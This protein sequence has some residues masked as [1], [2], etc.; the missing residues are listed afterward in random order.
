MFICMFK[1]KPYV[2]TIA[3]GGDTFVQHDAGGNLTKMFV[4]LK[5]VNETIYASGAGGLFRKS[6]DFGETWVD[7][8]RPLPGTQNSMDDMW[9]LD[10]NMGFV[11]ASVYEES[12][13]KG[14]PQTFDELMDRYFE[15]R[16]AN[17]YRHNPAARFALKEQGYHPN[18][19][20]AN[21]TGVYKTLDGGH[22]WTQI[23]EN[24]PYAAYKVHF[25]DEMNGM[26]LTDEWSNEKVEES[27]YVTHDG[28]ATWTM[29]Q[30]PASGPNNSLVLL[31]DVRML[32]PSLGYMGAAYQTV[33]GAS[34]MMLVTLDGGATWTADTLTADPNYMGID[35]GYGFNALDFA[36]NTRGWAAGMNLSIARYTGTN[37]PPTAEAGPDQTTVTGAAVQLDGSGSSDPD[38]DS[39]LYLWTVLD[40]PG[41]ATFDNVYI[42]NP[43]FTPMAVGDYTIQLQVS[44]IE[45]QATDTMTVTVTQAPLDD[46]DTTDDD[47]GGDDDAAADDDAAEGGDDDD[48]SGC[49]C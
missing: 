17:D 13:A 30:V 40:G 25:L 44:D 20:A 39:L 3:D 1:M 5:I 47:S 19:A 16:Q 12:A 36:D 29:G 42:V 9:W 21:G 45:F 14:E 34:S 31:T 11:A 18:G 38:G 23:W 26:I 6:T 10:E 37:A 33:F 41:E 24:F 35:A 49:G 46:D 27:I 28:G 2:W 48:D 15:A 22:T 4:D 7:L 32:T 43:T 8:P